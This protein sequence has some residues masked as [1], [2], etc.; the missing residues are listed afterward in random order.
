MKTAL[1]YI[2]HDAA[3]RASRSLL[4][5]FAEVE[6]LQ[7]S[8]K[9][10]SDFVSKAD[11]AAEQIIIRSLEKARPDIGF[12]AEESGGTNFDPNK[13]VWI[14]DPLDGTTNFLHGLP[15]FAISIALSEGKK[16][17]A[18][19]VYDPIHDECFFAEHK[20]GAYL[21]GNAIRASVRNQPSES[22]FATGIPFKGQNPNKQN[23]VSYQ[24]QEFMVSTAGVRRFGAAALDLAHVACGRYEGY[25]EE[26]LHVWDLAA[27]ML[28]VR[29]AGGMVSNFSGN[30]IN[31]WE[32]QQGNKE[33][34]ASNFPLH[35]F[36]Q[37]KIQAAKE[38]YS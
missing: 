29:E 11:I 10:P 12:L 33:M 1:Y 9:G 24:L 25:W 3:Q 7:V 19:M 28:I 17:V 8:I 18:G 4:R 30:K 32:T 21:N 2:M 20:K 36:M 15:H 27:G 31:H 26:G 35:N 23:R 16:L 22:L 38:K 34:L 37:E 14:I 13:P 6:K 5:D